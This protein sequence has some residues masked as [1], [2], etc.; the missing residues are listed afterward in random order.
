MIWHDE[1]DAGADQSKLDNEREKK[2]G[3]SEKDFFFLS[4]FNNVTRIVLRRRK[5]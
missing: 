2:R 1:Y 4:L 3:R 5:R